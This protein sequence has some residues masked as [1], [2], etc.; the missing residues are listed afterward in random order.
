MGAA[1]TGTGATGFFSF[2]IG[3]RNR[4]IK[5][6]WIRICLSGRPYNGFLRIVEVELGGI[7]VVPPIEDGQFFLCDDIK[8]TGWRSIIKFPY[9]NSLFPYSV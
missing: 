4:R 1:S 2:F 8:E 7:V 9:V 3:Y 5:R 6:Q